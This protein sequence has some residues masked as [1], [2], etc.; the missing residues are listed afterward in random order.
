MTAWPPP[1]DPTPDVPPPGAAPAT[2][3]PPA[4]AP[5]TGWAPGYAPGPA[6]GSGPGYGYGYA[7]GGPPVPAKRRVP[8][9]AVVLIALGTFV[10]GA[11]AGAVGLGLV[12]LAISD[13]A[14]PMNTVGPGGDIQAFEGSVGQCYTGS[15][16]APGAPVDCNVPHGIEVYA[17]ATAPLEGVSVRP[18]DAELSWFADDACLMAFA[19]YVGTSYDSSVLD[20]TPLVPSPEA[21]DAGARDVRC[22]LYD[23]D[24][25]ELDRSARNSRQ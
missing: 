17:A 13:D 4:A 14:M 5:G 19:P 21:W 1:T 3:A 6:P 20:Y 24:G 18:D 11:I 7:Y 22:V 25:A 12:G 15:A 9:W 8:V 23:L 16:D 10:A 2:W